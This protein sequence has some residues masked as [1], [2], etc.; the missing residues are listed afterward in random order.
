MCMGIANPLMK[1]KFPIKN[2]RSYYS[3]KRKSR[4]FLMDGE[5]DEE[6]DGDSEVSEEFEESSSD[7]ES[8][9]EEVEETEEGASSKRLKK[10][11]SQAGAGHALSCCTCVFGYTIIFWSLCSMNLL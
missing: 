9:I 4:I 6:F 2:L 10:A 3:E 5:F 1:P 11:A 7:F 8:S